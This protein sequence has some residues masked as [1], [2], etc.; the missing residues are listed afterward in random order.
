MNKRTPPPPAHTTPAGR[1]DEGLLHTVLGYQLAQAC[2]V[3]NQ[4][5]EAAVE[6]A[7]DLRKVEYTVLALVERND[8]LT[9]AQLASA[10]AFTPP[11]TAAWI[12]RLSR[13]GLIAREQHTSDRRALHI[14][15]TPEGRALVHQATALICAAEDEA[16]SRLTPAERLMLFEL[17]RKVATGR[18]GRKLPRAE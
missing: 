14:R 16:L 4:A 3:T 8:G 17:L 7:H 2:V 12:D 9:A 11:N 18:L 13:R 1:L 5:F 10:L 15:A 6:T